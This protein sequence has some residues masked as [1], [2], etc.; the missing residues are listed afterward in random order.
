MEE[1][2]YVQLQTLLIKLR[3]TAL[4]KIGNENLIPKIRD[5]EMKVIRYE[6]WLRN[7]I[8]FEEKEK[9]DVKK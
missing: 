7:H 8:T 4:K 2:E 3:V 9:N 5:N 1:D 6:D